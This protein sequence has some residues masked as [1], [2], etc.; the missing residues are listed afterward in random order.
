MLTAPNDKIPRYLHSSPLRIDDG[1]T[2][3]VL[4]A[5]IN[6]V[7]ILRYLTLNTGLCYLWIDAL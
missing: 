5:R 2:V 1:K 3:L 6:V 4:M 7:E